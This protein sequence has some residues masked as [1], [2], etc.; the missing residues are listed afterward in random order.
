MKDDYYNSVDIVRKKVFTPYYDRDENWYQGNKRQENLE[1][2]YFPTENVVIEVKTD[3]TIYEYGNIFFELEQISCGEKSWRP[4]GLA[5]EN[6]T[7]M[8][9]IAVPDEND[10]ECVGSNI[11]KIFILKDDLRK[12][13]NLAVK[14]KKYVPSPTTYPNGAPDYV[15]D[16]HKDYHAYKVDPCKN[17]SLRYSRGIILPLSFVNNPF[18]IR[19]V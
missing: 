19:R 3:Y 10:T 17:G 18:N 6:E 14:E 9:M 8:W 11:A 4:S 15:L 16:T 12:L 5:I 1:A 2:T 13:V 7:N